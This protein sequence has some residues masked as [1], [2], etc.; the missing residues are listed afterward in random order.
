MRIS[1]RSIPKLNLHQSQRRSGA[2]TVEYVLLVTLVGIGVLVGLA[3]IR[4]ALVGELED[5]ASA[6]SNIVVP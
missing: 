1:H 6:I 2:V 3:M 5:I 4:N